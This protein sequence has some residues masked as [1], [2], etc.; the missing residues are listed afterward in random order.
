MAAEVTANLL[1]AMEMEHLAGVDRTGDGVPGADSD[2]ISMSGDPSKTAHSDLGGS[3]VDGTIP[4]THGD[5]SLDHPSHA[6]GEG[7]DPAGRVESSEHPGRSKELGSESR[8]GRTR[9]QRSVGGGSE[10]GA[11]S[12]DEGRGGTAG[13]KGGVGDSEGGVEGNKQEEKTPG[14]GFDHRSRGTGVTAAELL[15]RGTRINPTPIRQEDLTGATPLR[16][17]RD[18]PAPAP[19]GAAPGG[20]SKAVHRRTNGAAR[21]STIDAAPVAARSAPSSPRDRKPSCS[22]A[23]AAALVAA[24]TEAASTE[25]AASAS[26]VAGSGCDMLA[27]RRRA[28]SETDAVLGSGQVGKNDTSEPKAFLAKT[29][30]PKSPGGSEGEDMVGEGMSSPPGVEYVRDGRALLPRFSGQRFASLLRGQPLGLEQQLEAPSDGSLEYALARAARI[31][32]ETL[33]TVFQPKKKTTGNDTAAAGDEGIVTNDAPADKRDAFDLRTAA[34]PLITPGAKAARGWKQLVFALLLLVF[35]ADGLR[36]R[37]NSLY[38]REGRETMGRPSTPPP[39][40]RFGA[41]DGSGGLLLENRFRAAFLPPSCQDPMSGVTMAV[42]VTPS[43]PCLSPLGGGAGNT[44]NARESSGNE[45]GLAQ[46][47]CAASFPL[48]G[49]DEA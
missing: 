31:P 8:P 49:T 17:L 44:R 26:G 48:C 45:A 12:I 38:W 7:L 40:R 18:N 35:A 42:W 20:K 19:L 46:P 24:E 25:A 9:N 14:R 43:G 34:I 47:L 29:D 13:L 39:T 1:H 37:W 11:S 22:I 32:L 41:S 23:A 30:V 4:P 2:S 33:R 28:S 5:G 16:K 27:H 36:H 6:A 15:R 10:G 21:T 3:S